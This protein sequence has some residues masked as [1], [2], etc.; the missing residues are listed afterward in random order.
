MSAPQLR[1]SEL[2]RAFWMLW[3]E[4]QLREALRRYVLDEG[5]RRRP[6]AFQELRQT[7]AARARMLLQFTASANG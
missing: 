1:Q 7:V 5:I 3:S 4:P 6:A 2:A